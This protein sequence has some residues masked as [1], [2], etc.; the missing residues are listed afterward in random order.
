MPF[1]GLMVKAKPMPNLQYPRFTKWYNTSTYISS[2]TATYLGH[3]AKA[4]RN[5]SPTTVAE[6][7]WHASTPP[8]RVAAPHTTT[9][10]VDLTTPAYMLGGTDGNTASTEDTLV[11]LDYYNPPIKLFH[12]IDSLDTQS[13]LAAGTNV[14]AFM[15]VLAIKHTFTFINH[16]RFPLEIYWAMLPVGYLWPVPTGTFD[17][18][19]DIMAQNYKKIT[20]PAIRDANDRSQKSSIDID[21]NLKQLWPHEY[22]MAP[23]VNMSGTDAAA[24]A[25]NGN[26]PWLN[27]HHSTAVSTF[28]NIPPGQIADSSKSAPTFG[29]NGPTCGLRLQW[30]AKLQ[31][32]RDLGS[33]TEDADHAGGDYTGNSYDVHAKMAWLIDYMRVGHEPRIHLGEKAY[34]N[35]VA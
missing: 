34:P 14:S 16:S 4:G 31:Q 12:D 18:H 20:V 27:I 35:S 23:G 15:R 28:R 17:P 25:A 2:A 30:W 21:V 9:S 32:P 33:T 26:S 7:H 22:D 19:V 29:T 24:S 8:A 5:F 3:I 10:A 13:D 1:S 11:G 6:R